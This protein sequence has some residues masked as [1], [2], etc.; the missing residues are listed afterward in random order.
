MRARTISWQAVIAAL[1]LLVGLAPAVQAADVRVID[2]AQITWNGASEPSSSMSDVVSAIQNQVGPNWTSFTTL[3][4]NTRDRTISFTYGQT[5]TTPIRLTSRM[6]CERSDFTSFM[7]SIRNEVYRQLGLTDWKDRYL[8]ILTPTAGCIWSGRAGIGSVSTKGGVMVLHN[9]A[10]AF[11]ITHEL[12]HNLG[13][14]HSN[15]LRCSTGATDGPWSQTCKAV[16]YGGSIDVMGNVDTTS[17]LST[18]HQWRMGLLENKEVQQSWLNESIELSASDVYGGTRAIFIRDGK[19]TYWIEYRR[20]RQG[21]PYNAG[22]VIYRTDP[23]SPSFIDSPNPD[24]REGSEP[25]LGVGTDIWMLNLDAY[26]Y[27]ATGRASGSMTLQPSK[28]TKLHSGNITLEAISA[29]TSDKVTVKITRK[30]DVTAPP[31]PPVT[32][33]ATWRYQ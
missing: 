18:Y 8:V 28:S 33:S 9:T 6:A 7:N 3:Q 4:G 14:G 16:E 29:S 11:V 24:D 27:S 20:P 19:S 32:P 17:P 23:P 12:G 15:M 5:L 31:F 26:S 1:F 21:V 25:G 22:L 2:V 13:L 10:S 30:A